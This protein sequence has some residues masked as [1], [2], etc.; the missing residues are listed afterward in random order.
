MTKT[1][2]FSRLILELWFDIFK[3]LKNNKIISF[4]LSR[5]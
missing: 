1:K 3:T 5:K 4:S 2:G